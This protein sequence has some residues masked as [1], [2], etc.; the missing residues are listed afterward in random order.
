MT[1]GNCAKLNESFH[2]V[3]LPIQIF[4]LAGILSLL[5][6]AWELQATPANRAALERHYDRFLARPSAKCI[7]C[8]LPSESKFPE[9]LG[10]FPHN[11]FGDRLRKLGEELAATGNKKDLSTRL[12]LVATED[13]DADGAANETELL[14]GRNPGNPQDKPSG[15]ELAQLDDR[16]AEFAQFLTSYRW[17]PF[18]PVKRPAVPVIANIKSEIRNPIDAFLSVERDAR[19]LKPRPEAPKEVLLRRVCIDLIGLNPTPEEQRAFLEDTSPNAY[20]RLVDHLLDDPRHGE[21]W[22]RHWMDVW[23]YSDWAGW[24][25]GGQIRDSQRHIWR[26]RD[27]IVESL[28]ADKPYDRMLTEMLAADEVAPEDSD[29]L[30]ATGFLVRNYKMLSR[31]QWLEDTVKHTS[32]ALFGVTMGCAKCHDHMADPISQREYYALRAVFEPH[33]VRTDRVPGELDL[34]KDGRPR[35]FDATNAPTYVF[36]RGDERHP[37]TN[38]VIAPAVPALLGGR[39]NV[40]PVNLPWLAGNPDQRDFVIRD[41]LAASEQTVTAAKA[42]WTKSRSA[43]NATPAELRATDLAL[44]LAEK[45]HAALVAV[46]AAERLTPS[47]SRRREEADHS[48]ALRLVTSAATNAVLLQRTAAIAEATLK[49]HQAQTALAAAPTN[50]LAE[51]QKKLSEADQQLTAA[52]EAL[53]KPLDAAF[54]PR[55]ATAYPTNSTGR[56]LA[57]AQWLTEPRN[58]L[59][60]RVAVNHVWLRHFGRGLVPT[61]AD[62]GRN[63]RPA[64]HPQLLDWLAAEFMQPETVDSR[65]ELMVDRSDGASPSI[66]HP[67]KALSVPWSFRHLHRLIVTSAAYR[68][69]SSSVDPA[70]PSGLELATSSPH[71]DLR[72]PTSIDPDNH[73]LWRMNSRRLEAEA[74]RDNVLYA[75]GTLDPTFGGPDIDQQQALTSPRRSL[76]LRHAAEKQAEF[77]QIFDGPA[78]TECYERRPSV[79]PQQALALGNSELA[80]KQARVLAA[81][82]GKESD[83][84][85]A[86]LVELAFQRILARR[87][88]NAE[89]QSCVEFFGPAPVSADL[90]EK[91]F[92]RAAEN[93]VLV[94]FNHNDFVTVR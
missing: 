89:R 5:G 25:D 75:A 61:P 59:T 30:R 27:W 6:A 67:L 76:Y 11:P 63:G 39:L 10:E 85:H 34:T 38:E 48:T 17:Q 50:K 14:L 49:R 8:H 43:A 45:K 41:T 2:V 92:A 33:Q 23:R 57:F 65:S 58:P 7:T 26:W 9:S 37:L 64:T 36:V 46:T 16:K 81:R 54:T 13:A 72:A 55:P 66:N 22:A 80:V 44:D 83:G 20:E 69:S 32:Q 1:A 19:G 78:V 71:S 42:A 40:Q 84:D 91:N 29:V 56:R 79:M 60:A 24:T 87:P 31:E 3:P 82:L 94:L 47:G 62:F 28:N 88:T 53:A 51:A 21:R 90:A 12:S 68:M 73:F 35:A 70:A 93:L 15:S 86:R 18:E 4:R 52:V 77:L 74:V